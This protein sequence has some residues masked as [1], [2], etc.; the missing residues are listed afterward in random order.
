MAELLGF[1]STTL[2]P[3][4]EAWFS[5]PPWLG[6]WLP[7]AAYFAMIFAML[8]WWKLADVQRPC[9]FNLWLVLWPCIGAWIIA[10]VWS[11]S[12]PWGVPIVG[13]TAATVQLASPWRGRADPQVRAGAKHPRV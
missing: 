5:V 8:D 7:H 13:L 9:R 2:M 10:S 6:D 4:H 12:H 3:A 11:H 1:D